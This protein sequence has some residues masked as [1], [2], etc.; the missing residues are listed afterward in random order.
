[1]ISMIVLSEQC[2][3]FLDILVVMGNKRGIF[4]KHVLS[5]QLLSSFLFCFTLTEVE[6]VG[7]RCCLDVDTFVV[8]VVLVI[9]YSG[10]ENIT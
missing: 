4:S 1:M 5:N 9:E 10:E 3:D 2:S 7:P 8:T 6:K